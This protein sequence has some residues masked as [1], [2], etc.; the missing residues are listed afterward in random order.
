MASLSDGTAELFKNTIGS[1]LTAFEANSGAFVGLGLTFMSLAITLTVLSSMY[2]WWVSGSF[3]DL[4]ENVVRTIIV[5]AP[6]SLIISDWVSYNET[7]TNFFTQQL[8]SYI[9]VGGEDKYQAVSKAISKL[10]SAVDVLNP[11]KQNNDTPT[12]G[13]DANAL[14]WVGYGFAKTWD[15]LTSTGGALVDGAILEWI[16]LLI[17]WLLVSALTFF[18][19]GA[20]LFAVFMPVA[21][22]AI[23]TI[24]G[25]L[26]VSWLPWK[27][28]ASMTERWTSFMISNGISF[29]VSMTIVSA[30]GDAV[31]E[32]V[33]YIM[34]LA[35]EASMGGALA[36]YGVGMIA[37]AAIY[38]FVINLLTSADS[39]AQ[40]MTGGA[41][42]G[43]GMFGKISSLASGA[44]VVKSG[45]S[46]LGG[47]LA[48][49][50][51]AGSAAGAAAGAVA[52]SKAMSGIKS[53]ISTGVS[54]INNSRVGQAVSSGS[55]AIANSKA[56]QNTKSAVTDPWK[57]GLLS[58]SFGKKK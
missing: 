40:G 8:P 41:A 39:I 16:Y 45:K 49:G 12:P 31:T 10:F 18:L 19:V 32:T 46:A 26:I 28:L 11:M 15:V 30:L 23:G 35:K 52:N 54:S 38:L 1:L 27:P 9:G 21:G 2:V 44:G 50:K 57:Q 53:G 58:R 29:V 13:T 20:M 48:A 14:V 55:S 47:S 17:M 33:T 24:F 51:G 37:V 42:L 7:F 22:L 25:P 4:L 34:N 43:E 3:Q 56:V 5:V 6:L 36:A